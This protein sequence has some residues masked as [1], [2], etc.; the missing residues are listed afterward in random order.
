MNYK[1]KLKDH[2]LRHLGQNLFLHPFKSLFWAEQKILFISDLHIGKAAHF[3][4][5][6]I[7]IS[8]QVHSADIYRIDYLLEHYEPKRLIFLGDLFHSHYNSSWDEFEHY[9]RTKK[10]L[11]IELVMGNHDILVTERYAFMDLHLDHLL[12]EPFILSHKPLAEK[13]RLNSYNLCGHLHPSI[14]INALARQSFRVACFYFGRHQAI[15]PAFG[16]FTGT[17]KLPKKSENDHI[18]AITEN[19]V[20][21]LHQNL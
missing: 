10:G 7:P 9:L 6:G 3:R 19:E 14:R 16:N 2:K 12:I 21:P 5:A 17:S 18:F 15:L 20:I 13:E 4:K 1:Y 11:H 8:E